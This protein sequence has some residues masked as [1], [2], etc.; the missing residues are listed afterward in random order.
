MRIGGWYQQPAA[1]SLRLQLSLGPIRSK[2]GHG[3]VAPTH[4][5]SGWRGVEQGGHRV[6]QGLD[7]I[8]HVDPQQPGC[9]SPME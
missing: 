6:E 1:L 9:A 7:S 3:S 8:L 4:A 2:G 5:Q